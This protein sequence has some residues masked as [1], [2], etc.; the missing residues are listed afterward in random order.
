MRKWIILLLFAGLMPVVHLRAQEKPERWDLQT[1]L[2][3]AREQN[4]QIRKSKIAWEE[5]TENVAQ[6]KAQLFPSLSFSS[7]HN[8]VNHPK[9][10][11][12]DKTIYT[13]SY[14]LNSS[15]TLYNGGKLRKNLNQKKTQEQIQMLGVEKAEDD[16][17]LAITE[18]YLQVLYAD[19]A[20]KINRN[21][22]ELSA[23]Q[24]ERG[25]E[26]KNAGSISLADLAQLEAQYSSDQ[27][28]LVVSEA[29][30][31][32]RKLELKQLL[33]LEI[34][35][36]MVLYIPEI[37]S[38]NVLQLLPSKSSV[39]ETALLVMPQVESSRLGIESAA[40]VKSEAKGGYL[41]S[42]K[43]N[44]AV[45]SSHKTGSDFSV[46]SQLK[47]GF[48][49]SVGLTLSVPIFS[50][51]NTKTAVKTA[52]LGIEDMELS[53]LNTQKELLK[54]VES[55]YLDAV[56][57]QN[58]YKAAGESLKSAVRSFELTQEQF[59]MGMKN[60]VELLTEKNKYLS[61]QQEVS[62]A[63]YMAVLNLLLLDFYQGKEIVL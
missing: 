17:E 23:A 14:Q 63:K 6:A 32:S 46:S 44:A 54:T 20:V 16:I 43:L 18:A 7:G 12:D 29:A 57:A 39:Y 27:Y 1:C 25:N 40:L 35:E 41:P 60:T 19:E 48:N 28:Q 38:E 58:R 11:D 2:Q 52:Q 59:H 49:E 42:L 10:L 33:E 13:G 47:H 3:Y 36:E 31:D 21:T 37:E 8:V 5:S 9:G 34:W 61:A 55:V 51:R 50:N 62:Q 22:V 26:L 30:L 15:V 45:G 56:S 53:Y 24:K 4:I